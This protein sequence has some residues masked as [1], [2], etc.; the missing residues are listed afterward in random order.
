[1]EKDIF[2]QMVDRWESAVVARTQIEK[3]SGGMMSAKYMANLDSM[4][5]G[6]PGKIH[7]GRKVAYSTQSLGDWLRAR[8]N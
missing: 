7:C 2:Q 6:C 5:I 4:G 8:S 3:F 1:M